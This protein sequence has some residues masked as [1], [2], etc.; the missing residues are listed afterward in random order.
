[1]KFKKEVVEK[2]KKSFKSNELK[3]KVLDKEWLEKNKKTGIDSTG[4]CRLSVEVIY[5]LFGGKD[6]WTVKIISK[7]AWTHGSHY[8]LENKN[9]KEIVDV[10]SDQYESLGIEIP[11]NLGKGTG[12]RSNPTVLSKGAEIL[13]KHAELV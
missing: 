7:K 10:A 12:L 5:K 9:T 13:A 8:Y 4:F 2:L 3:E 11:Y 1:M 6:D